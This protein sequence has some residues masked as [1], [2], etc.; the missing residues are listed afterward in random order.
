SFTASQQAIELQRPLTADQRPTTAD[1][2]PTT[3]EFPLTQSPTHPITQVPMLR[4]LGQI[5]S[6]YIIAEGPDGLYLID[7]HAA[8]ERVLYEQLMAERASATIATQEL[9][10]PLPLRL[11]PAQYAALETH[12]DALTSVGFRF[13]EF[14]TQTILLR[15]VP[16]VMQTGEPRETLMRLLDELE[17]G[18]EPLEKSA[19]ARLIASVC[20]SIAIKGGQILSLD[21]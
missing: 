5:L 9:L 8:H 21:E 16:A 12:R 20:K 13:E 2:R 3:D 4:V 17:Q 11:T 14:G 18:E 7:Q 6:T 15:A 1:R 19:E 10:D